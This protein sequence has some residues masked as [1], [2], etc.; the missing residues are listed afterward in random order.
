MVTSNCD[1]L[2]FNTSSTFC[3]L[4]VAHSAQLGTVSQSQLVQNA[5]QLFKPNNL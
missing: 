4:P 1:E 3:H 5:V 2:T